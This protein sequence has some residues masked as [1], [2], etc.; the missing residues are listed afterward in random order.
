[1]ELNVLDLIKDMG[2]KE[3]SI[4]KSI[5]I[6]PIFNTDQVVT[7]VSGLIHK[8]YI[9]KITK[10]GWYKIKPSNLNRAKVVGEADFLEIDQYLKNLYKVRIIVVY[11]DKDIFYG[12][13]L[14]NNNIGLDFSQPVP[15]YLVSE[16][17]VQFFDMITCRFDGANV[18]YH[19]SDMSNDPA[20]AEYLRDQ[21]DKYNDPKK[22]QYKGLTVEEKL[23]YSLRHSLD[24]KFRET[25]KEN[26]IK[27]DVEHSGGE[28][29]KFVEKKD[30]FSVTYKVDGQSYTSYVSKDTA[31]HVIT[32]GICLSGTDRKYDLASLVN[33]LREGQRKGRIHRYN[34]TR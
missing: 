23:A 9:P 34:N 14:K 18:W 13:P 5:F 12:I 31:H 29:V 20:K 11:K 28:F 22:I 16:D 15:I 1:M 32:A 27:K 17:Q 3:K 4:S 8:L 26:L 33:V 7:S 30:H 10:P 21:F 24:K 2:K 25:L 19:E 6:S